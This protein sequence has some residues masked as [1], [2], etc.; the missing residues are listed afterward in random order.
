MTESP[1]TDR[2]PTP[3]ASAPA[4]PAEQAAP[5]S[6]APLVRRL[7]RTLHGGHRLFLLGTGVLA[8]H[9]ADDSF[10]QPQ[11]GTSAGDHLAGGLVPIAA[12]A[13]VVWAYPRLRAG[14]RGA[15][16]LCAGLF[17]LVVSL[18]EAGYYTLRVGPSGDDY[19]GLLAIPAA[20]LLIG[21]GIATLWRQPAS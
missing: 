5:A 12:L 7:A 1:T 17:G 2:R 10:L 11:P 20:L 6:R 9:I 8:L 14:A 13:A 4:A 3:T 21:L 15:L 19:T 16:A 18:P